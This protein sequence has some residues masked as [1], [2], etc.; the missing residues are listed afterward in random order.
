MSF[1]GDH[2]LQADQVFEHSGKVPLFDP[3]ADAGADGRDRQRPCSVAARLR[4]G[5]HFEGVD[6]GLEL[7][8][9]ITEDIPVREESTGESGSRETWHLLAQDAPYRAELPRRLTPGTGT[10][11]TAAVAAAS[12][13]VTFTSGQHRV[14]SALRHV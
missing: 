5:C 4:R 3:V 1:A 7:V 12:R 14:V 10:D 8:V 2:A 9:A 6:A 11:R 13:P